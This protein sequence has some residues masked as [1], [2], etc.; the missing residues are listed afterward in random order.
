MC[1]LRK[2][3][4]EHSCVWELAATFK[5][6]PF[7]DV[8]PAVRAACTR[9]LRTESL[10]LVIIWNKKI[11]T[12]RGETKK[13][14]HATLQRPPVSYCNSQSPYKG[15]RGRGSCPCLLPLQLSH[16]TGPFRVCSQLQAFPW[17]CPGSRSLFSL[18]P[19][20]LCRLHI[21]RWAFLLPFPAFV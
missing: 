16:I 21:S 17:R 3:T 12:T 7:W 18:I 4:S 14:D 11:L 5:G 8:G 15:L 19:A 1:L 6:V 9:V 13:S 2:H 10:A 20:F